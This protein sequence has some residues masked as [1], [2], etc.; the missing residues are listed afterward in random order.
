MAVRR[1]AM[2]VAKAMIAQ[3]IQ[4]STDKVGLPSPALFGKPQE[5]LEISDK[6]T[7]KC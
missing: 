5:E 2:N 7:F 1:T 4:S 6:N 3:E